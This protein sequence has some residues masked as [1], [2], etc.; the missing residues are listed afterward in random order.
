MNNK[1]IKA[2]HSHQTTNHIPTKPPQSNHATTHIETL[3]PKH[4]RSVEISDSDAHDRERGSSNWLYTLQGDT[5][6]P[7]RHRDHTACATR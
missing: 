6:G 1:C 4:G 5:P 7:T 3:R 2:N